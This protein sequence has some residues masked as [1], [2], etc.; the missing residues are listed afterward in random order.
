MHRP[1]QD[2]GRPPIP[3]VARDKAE[4]LIQLDVLVTDASGNPVLG[5]AA[6]DLSLLENDRPQTVL[7]FQAFNGSEMESEPPVKI[8]LLVDTIEM[9]ANLANRE[10]NSVDSYLRKNGGH[11]DHPLAVFLLTDSG[12][13]TVAHPDRDGN[14]LAREIEHNDLA[15]IRHNR[16]WQRTTAPTTGDQKDTPSESALK[17]L[18]QIAADERTRPGRKTSFVDRPWLGIGQRRVR[19]GK[20]GIEAPLRGGLVVFNLA[21]GSSSGSLQLHRRRN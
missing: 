2:A 19:S 11:L 7:S 13:W 21:S 3:L 18:G 4:G 12:L 8:I 5:L 17:A 10:R 20:T 6:A 15:L 9:P 14:V 1:A 16:G